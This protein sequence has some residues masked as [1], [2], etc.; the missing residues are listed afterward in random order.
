MLP[1]GCVGYM[2]ARVLGAAPI[3]AD[4][5]I[6]QLAAPSDKAIDTGM[7]LMSY[8]ICSIDAIALAG[9][10]R[11]LSMNLVEDSM[12]GVLPVV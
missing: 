11:L 8:H 3:L 4:A 12:P 7:P 1:G 10:L 5:V 2:V 6:A 9:C